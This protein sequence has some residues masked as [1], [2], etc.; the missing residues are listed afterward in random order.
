MEMILLH[1]HQKSLPRIDAKAK[2][3]SNDSKMVQDRLN[4][5]SCCSDPSYDSPV[6]PSNVSNSNYA[7]SSLCVNSGSASYDDMCPGGAKTV[8]PCS[9]GFADD[10]Y[11]DDYNHE[12]N[13]FEDDRD[14][15]TNIYTY[16]SGRL[17]LVPI[18]T[19]DTGDKKILHRTKKGKE[20]KKKE[21]RLRKTSWLSKTFCVLPSNL[22][23]VGDLSNDGIITNSS[24]DDE[25]ICFV[26][27]EGSIIIEDEHDED[28][29][30]IPARLDNR[31][32]PEPKTQVKRGMNSIIREQAPRSFDDAFDVLF[33]NSLICNTWQNWYDEEDFQMPNISQTVLRFRSYDYPHNSSCDPTAKKKRIQYLRQNMTPFDIDELEFN[34]VPS[35]MHMSLELKKKTTSFSS[36]R[37]KAKPRAK[38]A[39]RSP[40]ED[41]CEWHSNIIATCGNFSQ[42]QEIEIVPSDNFNYD[43]DNDFLC[44]DSDPSDLIPSYRS[45]RK[46][47]LGT[48]KEKRR[49][50]ES[51]IEKGDLDEATSVDMVSVFTMLL[52]SLH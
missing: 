48:L 32:L 13:D 1:H 6:V 15:S 4:I 41:D 7:D 34:Q 36:A 25:N 21:S 5:N 33:Q 12:D 39:K 14:E 42:T 17:P 30:Y 22:D 16:P 47:R 37:K 27:D 49:E 38:S 3:T 20:E 52:F 19:N 51:T 35:N 43:D 46:S 2:L 28:E 24:F 44:Y 45:S 18:D 31:Y 10:Y 11:F 23:T 40:K 8:T 29:I 26:S 9:L 50:H